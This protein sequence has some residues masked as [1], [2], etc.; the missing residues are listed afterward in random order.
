MIIKEVIVIIGVFSGFGWMSVIVLVWVGYVVY[1]G[2]CEIDGC[3]VVVVQCLQ[4]FVSG[5][6]LD[7]YVIE[8]DIVDQLLVDVVIE[9]IFVIQGCF[10]VV[11]YNV[12]YMVYGLVEVFMFEQFVVFYDINVFG[13]QWV[14]CVVLLYLWVCG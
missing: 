7:L 9:V 2:M 3:N 4:Q 1:V 10:D 14:N 6:G 5:E 13:M 12:G 11:V 8:M